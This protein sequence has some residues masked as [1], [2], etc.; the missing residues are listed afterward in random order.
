MALD[1]GLIQVYT[2]DGK[3]KTTAALG[4]ALR[5]SGEGL[6]VYII[7][8]MKGWPHY[9]ELVALQHQPNITLVQFGRPEFVKRES[10]DPRD[11]RMAQD[12]WQHGLDILTD[13]KYDVSSWT[14]S[15]L[16]WIMGCCRWI[17]S[18][19]C[20]TPS[21]RMLSWCSRDGLLILRS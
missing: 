1:R 15:T 10:P 18:W 4:L 21:R 8:F 12:A 6:R 14:R 16:R 17:R 5:A 7:Q 20:S 3:G 13:G 2:G 11:V 9:G 19:R